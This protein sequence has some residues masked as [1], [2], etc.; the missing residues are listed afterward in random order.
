MGVNLFLVRPPHYL[1]LK[2]SKE[3]SFCYDSLMKAFVL[4][5]SGGSGTGK[6]TLA[7]GL[8]DKYPSQV[9]VFHLDDYFRPK[10]DVPRLHGFINYDDPKALYSQKI[11]TDLTALVRGKPIIVNTKSPRLNPDFLKT[12]Q[13]IPVELRGNK[14]IVVEGFL[15]LHFIGLRT[16]FDYSIYL[17]APFDVH[18]NRRAGEKINNYPQEYFELVLK[19]MHEKYVYPYK[20]YANRIIYIDSNTKEDVLSEVN[21]ILQRQSVF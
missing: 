9:T 21:T 13:R 16:L 8:A 15:S 11:I 19:P 17:D 1:G 5:L 14:L 7:F 18:I 12:R 6:S 2:T 10:E 20:K 4:G 3:K